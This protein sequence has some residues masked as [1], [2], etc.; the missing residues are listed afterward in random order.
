MPL[1]KAR[2][3]KLKAEQR[4]KPMSNLNGITSV[5]PKTRIV[6]PTVDDLVAS[7]QISKGMPQSIDD[8]PFS[9]KRQSKGVMAS[10][11]S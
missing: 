9:K 10:S 3:R 8:L 1:S 4:V 6:K 11:H 2:M 5:K 7:G